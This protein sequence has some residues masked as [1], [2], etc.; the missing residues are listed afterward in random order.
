[1]H[2]SRAASDTICHFA[3]E[4]GLFL[5]L[6]LF[7]CEYDKLTQKFLYLFEARNSMCGLSL[8]FCHWNTHPRL[9]TQI[10]VIFTHS[11]CKLFIMVTTGH[12][13]RRSNANQKL[14]EFNYAAMFKQNVHWQIS[15]AAW[16]AACFTVGDCS[17]G[18]TVGAKTRRGVR[19]L[20]T[21]G[22]EHGNFLFWFQ[23][24]SGA[25][26]SVGLIG[27]K[28]EGFRKHSW[29]ITGSERPQWARRRKD[30]MISWRG[31]GNQINGCGQAET[32]N[33]Q[34]H[35]L[36]FFKNCFLQITI[37]GWCRLTYIFSAWRHNA[38]SACVR[39]R[40][41][42]NLHFCCLEILIKSSCYLG[43]TI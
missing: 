5:I 9:L 23:H 39:P 18:Q 28:A 32:I 41:N 3:G 37:L 25:S 14:T 36:C 30:E 6:Q 2:K 4:P 15:V 27:F 29:G 22:G 17:R 42:R 40:L 16:M 7:L 10:W 8:F 43:K 35:F 21:A 20:Q 31:G 33:M 26:W 12:D 19:L 11:A 13:S 34:Y 38:V 24:E 1:M